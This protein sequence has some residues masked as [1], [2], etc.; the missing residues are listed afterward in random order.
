M[1]I[2]KES[3]LIIGFNTRPL[4]F[5]LCNAGYDVYAI[6]FFGDLDLYPFVKDTLILTK[7]LNSS[8]DL[9]KDSYSDFIPA[10]TFRFLEKYSDIDYYL[11]GSGLDDHFEERKLILNML[12]QKR[13]Q[14][15][16]L[17]NDLDVIK[18]A[19][20]IEY[21]Y[22]FL[23]EFDYKVPKIISFKENDI[24]LQYPL[25]LKKRK[26]SGGINI[27]KIKNN[28]EM[29]LTLKFLKKDGF[30]PYEWI[31]QEFI[32][33]ISVSCTVIANGVESKVIS[34]N[35]QIIG[36]KFV[37]S[38]KEFMYCGNVVPANLLEND[39]ELIKKISLLLSNKLNLKGI[40]GFDYVL[41]DHYP[42]LME[43]NPRIP[44][45]IRVSEEALDV[46]LLD[47]HVKSFKKEHW[48][49]I[50]V[51]IDKTDFKNFSTKLIFF[52]PKL[53]NGKIISQINALD[54]IHDKSDP[55]KEI[56]KNAP[57]CSILFKDK[58]FAASYF[59]ALKIVDNIMKII[60]A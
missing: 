38:P 29:V 15:H 36:E 39:N 47:L 30:N 37:N 41:K 1:A 49:D 31:I 45:S 22:D 10:L 60:S 42:Y 28:D 21:L 44:G 26:S 4:A 24:S 33:G 40:N 18:R 35:R 32:E 16:S 54:N 17:N 7:E 50:K 59:G 2:K 46:N 53:I 55:K 19:R 3:V 43:I 20:D 13:N 6:D 56:L 52:A 58:T 8:Y 48:N 23:R 25:I 51:L 5:S 34:I 27:Y 14:I 9:L 12:I 11:I 57:V